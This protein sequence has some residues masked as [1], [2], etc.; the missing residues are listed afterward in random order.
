MKHVNRAMENSTTLR[1]LEEDEGTKSVLDACKILLNYTVHELEKS[2]DVVEELDVVKI[3]KLLADMKI[4]F[5]ATIAYQQA[6]LDRFQK[7]KSKSHASLKMKKFL[8]ITTQLSRIGLAIACELE[9]QLQQLQVEG[10]FARRR[11]LLGDEDRLPVLVHFDWTSFRERNQ[12]WNRRRRLLHKMRIDFREKD[13][14]WNRRRLHQDIELNIPEGAR[15]LLSANLKP[16]LV[17][18]KDGSGYCKTLNE[19]KQKIPR[20]STKPFVIHVKE[21][22]YAENVEIPSEMAHVVLIADGK[23]KT[24]IT[25]NISSGQGGNPTTFFTATF[26]TLYAF[27][28]RQFY[29]DCTIS[30]RIDFIFGDA[31]V[32]FQNCTF[33][34]RK[35]QKGKQ[36]V[37]TVQ[38]R[39]DKKLPTG[40]VIHG[41]QIIPAPELSPVKDE[42]PV[43]LGR[44]WGALST[45]IIME[46]Y[47]DDMVHP[48]GWTDMASASK[49]Q[50]CTYLVLP[51]PSA[52]R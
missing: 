28:K 37:I 34:V 32:I 44:P 21:G 35:P 45:T 15:R 6:C 22:V 49:T 33:L 8:N 16:D 38:K 39:S 18:A 47:I 27:T 40:T 13:Q 14:G 43:Y 52:L 7:T 9:D 19:A 29:R 10:L 20:R 2:F 26:D 50:E 17:V 11:R 3:H 42:F 48:D 30:G 46:T 4:W 23:D 41:G 51:H 25:G 31:S 5:S 36:N 1:E 12:N 24:R